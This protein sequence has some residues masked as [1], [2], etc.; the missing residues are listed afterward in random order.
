[1]LKCIGCDKIPEDIPE[2]K[3]DAMLEEMTPSQWVRENETVG[4]WGKEHGPD[5]FYCTSCYVRHGMPMRKE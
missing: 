3:V 5:A 2:Y 4:K 1:M